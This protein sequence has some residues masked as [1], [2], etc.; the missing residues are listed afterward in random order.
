MLNGWATKPFDPP[1]TTN[2]IYRIAG[3]WVKPTAKIEGG[4]AA[5]FVTIKEEARINKRRSEK[6][7]REKKKAAAAAKAHATE[8]EVEDSKKGQKVP[9]DLSH[10]ECFKCKQPGHYSTS[11]EC[12]LHPEN[13]KNKAKAGFV[14]NTWADAET[15]IF[16]TLQVDE[17]EE[18]VINNAVHV[19]QGL[20]PTEVLL[21]NQANISIM[22]LMLLSNVRAAPKKIRVKGVGG[23]QL[24]VDKVG[25]LQG[26]FEVY[27]C[28][29]TKANILS[30]AD[31]E[32]LYSITYDRGQALTVHMGDSDVK[33]KRREKLYIADWIGKSDT[34]ATVHENALVY[35]KEELHRAREVYELVKNSG[36]PSPNE[37]LHLLTDG[38][39]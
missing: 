19:T 10:I 36:Y 34:Y 6:E 15:C 28:E 23:P 17:L 37:A 9:K 39:I 35:T 29:Y 32:D 13:K 1:G 2:D 26:F 11:K 25:D 30:F 7:K 27:A 38:N 8:G 16:T 24:I 20:L 3:A 31:V 4:T 22:H 33:F 14:N 18:H 21:D 5:M 12:P